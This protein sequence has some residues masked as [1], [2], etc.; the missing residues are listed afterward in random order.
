[1][2]SLLSNWYLKLLLL[3]VGFLVLYPLLM[4]VYGSF[5]G[6]GP[7]TESALNLDGYQRAFS[8]IGHL[9]ILW[10]TIWLS[11]IRTLLVIMLAIF[12]AWVVTRTDTPWRGGLEF[13]IWLVFLGLPLLPT[14]VAWTLL[15]GP[16]GFM[17]QAMTALFGLEKPLLN[18]YSYGGIIW[19]SVAFLTSIVFVIIT[20][21][22]RGMDAAL[23]ESSRMSGA[24][25]ITTIRRVT[26]PLLAPALL[27][28]TLLSFI[29]LVESFEVELILGYPAGI[30]VYTTQIWRLLGTVPADFPQAMALSSVVLVAVMGLLYFQWR[31][32]G[33]RQY[34]TITGR[35]FS[36]HP[37]KLGVWRYVTFS[38]VILYFVFAFVLPF[39]TLI[40]GS[41]MK[42]W[43]VWSS[44]PFTTKHWVW[45]I[46]DA[47]VLRSVKNTLIVGVGAA[48]IGMLLYSLISYV[49]VK[50]SFSG[51]RALDMIS[52]LPYGVP[53]L[54]LALGFLWAYTGG[55]PVFAPLFGTLWLLM[56]A[57]IVRGLPLGCRVMNG[58]MYQLGR[59]LEES[60]RVLG[61][62]W[63]RTFYR[64]VA[65][66]L[67]P[68]FVSAWILLFL[69]AVRDVVTIIVLYMPSSRLLSVA[70]FEHW[71]ASEYEKSVVIGVMM[72]LLM[73]IGA[74]TVRFFGPKQQVAG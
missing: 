19:V 16:N 70:L 36:T 57:F 11:A 62:S 49:T 45:A 56:M 22:F 26:I 66:I 14:T 12:F 52:W 5:R 10:T 7:G 1:V 59:E 25:T 43:G 50:T 48:T 67:S 37:A 30:Y 54:V 69:I 28:A 24:S 9:R 64:I 3:I 65:P 4:L 61:A 8:D 13:L 73:L 33:N 17:N 15:A 51:R 63:A 6:G 68:A 44:E 39:L 41:F 31:L 58:A 35:G 74:I 71:M 38:A 34:V 23:E 46:N 53:G 42:L 18:V 20:P 72:T 47:R 21:A 29:R 2:R 27:G 32:L 40:L 55:L 60:S